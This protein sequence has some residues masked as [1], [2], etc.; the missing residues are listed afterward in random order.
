MRQLEEI[1]KNRV[2]EKKFAAVM[3]QSKIGH[4][5][6]LLR[7]ADELN[8]ARQTLQE[9]VRQQHEETRHV[10]LIQ[11]YFR[12][13]LARKAARRWA[14]KLAEM[15]AVRVL[16]DAAT[17][18]VQRYYRGH[19]GRDQARRKRAA[20]A[21]FIDLMRVEESFEQQSYFENMQQ[22]SHYAH[23]QYEK[24]ESPLYLLCMTLVYTP[25]VYL[26]LA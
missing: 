1:R 23:N 8:E 26:C 14:L 13:F 6:R 15:N 12:G 2:R 19:L 21:H 25:L 3:V 17:L 4:T 18:T 5:R 24:G 16:F 9:M 20:F 7:E 22:I 11:R 10:R